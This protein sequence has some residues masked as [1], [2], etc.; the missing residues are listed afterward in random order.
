MK[1]LI[2]TLTIT[3]VLFAFVFFTFIPSSDGV[4]KHIAGL[5]GS[6]DT[7]TEQASANTPEN[8]PSAPSQSQPSAD[9][10]APSQTQSKSS[11]SITKKTT[12]KPSNQTASQPSAT[13]PEST[14]AKQPTTTQ[15]KTPTADVTS[16]NEEPPA[17][18]GS[19][20]PTPATPPPASTKV[21]LSSAQ[22]RMLALVNGER[23]KLGLAPLKI[24]AKLVE[25]AL[26]KANDMVSNNYFS[27]T[28]PTYGTPFDMLKKYGVTYRSAGEN[29]AG[30]S[31]VDSAHT[32]FMHSEGH[33][34]NILNTTYDEIGIGIVSSPK[35]GYIYVEIFI[36]V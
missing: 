3:I 18:S 15:P 23:E 27:H 19:T 7:Q 6:T 33:R 12:V 35:Y 10:Q 13:A 20:T 34:A 1:K 9:S 5:F 11:D 14:P 36:G 8:V 4:V 17:T 29:L 25:L 24:N 2:G 31:S 26:L 16:G 30:N 21:S 28:S 32:A 22:Q